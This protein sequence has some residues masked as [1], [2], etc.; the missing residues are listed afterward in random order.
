MNMHSRLWS[1]YAA[2][3]LFLILLAAPVRHVLEASMT[4]QMLVQIPLLIVVGWLLHSAVPKRLQRVIA[5]WNSY[6][7]SGL[8]LALFTATYWMLPRALDAASSDPLALALKYLTVPLLLGL[9]LALSW[10]RMNF[11]VKG[12]L[13]VEFIAT[14]FRLGWLYMTSPTRLCSNYLIDDQQRLGQYMLII[15]CALLVWIA[16]KLLWGRF[17]PAVYWDRAD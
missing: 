14:F 3:L 17:T 9:P 7:I 1:T 4:A 8:L 10:P 15:G 2:A 13:L 16:G 5:D 11:I 12:V 6:G